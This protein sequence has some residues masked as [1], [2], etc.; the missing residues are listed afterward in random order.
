MF[1]Q[2]IISLSSSAPNFC[3][4]PNHKSCT[5]H[6][7]LLN[8]NFSSPPSA[9]LFTREISFLLPLNRGVL[10]KTW[11]NFSNYQLFPPHTH[12]LLRFILLSPIAIHSSWM[13]KTAADKAKKTIC[14]ENIYE[15]FPECRLKVDFIRIC[16]TILIQIACLPKEEFL[17]PRSFVCS[18]FICIIDSQLQMRFEQ[19]NF[20]YF[21]VRCFIPFRH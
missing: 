6:L 11:E 21:I 2:V 12:V 8:F 13:G 10:G 1:L 18:F 14:C 7:I 3:E 19:T 15:K 4:H 20:F 5:I 9:F 16:K 17:L